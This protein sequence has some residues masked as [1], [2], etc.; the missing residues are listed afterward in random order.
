ML[1]SDVKHYNYQSGCYRIL[2]I[3][4]WEKPR[5]STRAKVNVMWGIEI[6]LRDMRE[7]AVDEMDLGRGSTT[8]MMMMMKRV[9]AAARDDDIPNVKGHGQI[10]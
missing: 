3:N 1:A 9:V 7:D 6:I 5:F 2:L 8:M 4:A 10:K